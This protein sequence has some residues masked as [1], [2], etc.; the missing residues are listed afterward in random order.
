MEALAQALMRLFALAL[1]LEETWFD[2]K[3]HKHMTNLT[4]SHYPEQREAPPPGQLRAG[5][6]T[7]YGSLTILCTE[8]KPG[9]LEV[10][11]AAREWKKVPIIPGTFIINIGDL[12]ARWTNDHWVSTMH[13]V[14][15]PPRDQALGSD[16]V[17]LTFFHQPNYDAVVECLPGFRDAGQAKYP[18]ITSGEHLMTKIAKM[19]SVG[20]QRTATSSHA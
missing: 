14:V 12:M 5:A 20:E 6:H 16:R 4:V 11:T 13:R 2:D 7:D 3:I 10:Q 9:G 15:N 18:P 8:D 19:Q 1:R 17:S